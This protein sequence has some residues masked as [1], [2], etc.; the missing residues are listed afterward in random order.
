MSRPLKII[1]PEEGC[2]QLCVTPCFAYTHIPKN[3][4]FNSKDPLTSNENIAISQW[5]ILLKSY[6]TQHE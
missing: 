3:V 5:F 1:L 6:V 2:N 4:F